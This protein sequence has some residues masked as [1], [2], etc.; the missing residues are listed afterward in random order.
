[1]IRYAAAL[2]GAWLL[3]RLIRRRFGWWS[4]RM[5]GRLMPEMDPES[6]DD[7]AMSAV[8]SARRV[9]RWWMGRAGPP[10]SVTQALWEKGNYD[11]AVVY[12]KR[13]V[14]MRV[15]LG[16]R[17]GEALARGYLGIAHTMA[18]DPGEALREYELAL[19]L[20]D[21]HCEPHDQAAIR[22]GI[23]IVHAEKG[24]RQTALEWLEGALATFRELGDEREHT[25]LEE[26]RRVER[27]IEEAS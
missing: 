12:A 14:Q 25:T 15:E 5:L 26:I 24:D 2:A 8:R 16:D 23:G 21:E 7:I 19:P 3:V 1:M 27:E 4:A 13:M 9:P 22:K 20:A 17:H 10:E 18:G 11:G 6:I